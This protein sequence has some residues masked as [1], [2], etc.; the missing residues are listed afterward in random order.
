MSFSEIKS[1]WQSV[2]P[3]LPIGVSTVLLLAGFFL[4]E[5]FSLSAFFIA[6]LL[7]GLPVIKESLEQILHGE[8]FD[9]CF[10]M[11]VAACGAIALGEWHEAVAVMLLYQIGEYLQDRAVASSRAS[12]TSLAR[13]RP[14]RADVLRGGMIVSVPAETVSVG[15]EIRLGA[16]D[17]LPVDGTVTEGQS[18]LDVSALTGESLP[19]SVSEGDKVL[20]GSINQSGVLTVR[21]DKK[22]EEST[23]ARIL[24]MTEEASRQKTK[25]EQFL[26]RFS[27][28]YTPTVVGLAVL[29]AI[30]PPL[31][32]WGSFR[33]FLYRSLN[34]LVISC[35]CALII[36]VPLAYFAGLGR[37]SRSGILVKGSQFLDALATVRI[38]VFDKTG[39]LTNGKFVL[40]DIL[41]CG[42]TT[43]EDMLRLAAHAEQFSRHPLAKAVTDAYTGTVDLGAVSELREEAGKGIVCLFDGKPL[44]IGNGEYVKD[45]G[46]T[47]QDFQGEY[48]GVHLAYAGEYF[49]VLLFAGEERPEAK[50]ALQALKTLGVTRTLILSGDRAAN[51][52][53]IRKHL[54]LD[55]FYA[56]LLP[57]DK[58]EH[59]RRLKES[60]HEGTVLYVGD[61]I[62]DAPVLALAD[63]G[64]AMGG[65][66]SDAAMEAADAVIMCD[67][68]R[69]LP[70]A[71]KISRKTRRI[72]KENIVMALAV[73]ITVLLLSA[74]GA[75]GL[76]VSVFSDVGVC[77]LAVLNSLRA[78]RE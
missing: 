63:V 22:F 73:K 11:T 71:V 21:V 33:T 10:L 16:G 8:V 40:K 1:R 34:F 65:I 66:G 50:D 78:M 47:P 14:D 57:Q 61:G 13:M 58:V 69:R 51:V 7:P 48:V 3:L 46:F 64:I 32:G 39:T 24:S 44:I 74:L 20:A 6:F 29:L 77:L 55:E 49:G 38:A 60:P 18:A 30:L 76:S 31:F 59:I 25:T 28:G 36:S 15:E 41:S 35:P 17:R 19:V 70:L 45:K 75:V 5:P 68:L 26:T 52:E 12:I 43:Q 4:P 37:A 56:E 62:N 23:A 54:L 27:R 72:A 42:R 53:P 2:S 67:D 9:E